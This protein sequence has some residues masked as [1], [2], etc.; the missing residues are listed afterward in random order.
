MAQGFSV[1]ANNNP[2]NNFHIWMV[3]LP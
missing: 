3:R 2:V 1:I